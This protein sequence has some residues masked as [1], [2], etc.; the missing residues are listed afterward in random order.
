MA[1]KVIRVK[2]CDFPNCPTPTDDVKRCRL[3]VDGKVSVT[4][5]CAGDR[6]SQP[7]DVLIEHAHRRS[8]RRG[9]KVTEPKRTTDTA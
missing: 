4:D 8:R 3:E 1:D 9:I 6:A 5:L 2:E 7:I